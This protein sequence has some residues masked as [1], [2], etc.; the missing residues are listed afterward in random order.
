M[1]YSVRRI[2]AKYVVLVVCAAESAAGRVPDAG[3]AGEAC[4]GGAAPGS[5]HAPAIMHAPVAAATSGNRGVPLWN[6]A[7]L[8][9]CENSLVIESPRNVGPAR[10]LDTTYYTKYRKGLRRVEPKPAIV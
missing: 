1:P 4:D 8:N 7:I 9:W 6:K 10:W 5:A 2:S 3:E